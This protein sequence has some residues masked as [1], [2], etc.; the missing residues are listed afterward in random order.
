MPGLA[1]LELARGNAG[2]A[3]S[4]ITRALGEASQPFQRPGL[5]AA[6][7]EIDV[8]VGDVAA[9]RQAA[10]ELASVAARS[11]SPAL[12]AM[13][14][15][16]TGAVQLAAGE[17]ADALV[18]LRAASVVWLRLNVP[19]EAARSAVLIGRA[20]AALD[21]S[22]AAAL[23]YDNARAVFE[24]LGAAPDLQRA[25]ELAS[26]PPAKGTLSAR[27]L[28]VLDLV[29]KGKTSREIASMLTISEHTVR[30]HIENTFAKLGVNSR[31]AAI[32]YAYEHDLL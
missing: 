9:G 16:A 28:E 17:T 32:A 4:S 6:A 10:A 7:V 25:R 18:H 5:L 8:A 15:H 19:Y 21:D 27:E 23:E 24:S 1:L 30:R 31:A 26:G 20:C 11:S 29:A 22:I 12:R 3:A 13:A 2:A 14:D